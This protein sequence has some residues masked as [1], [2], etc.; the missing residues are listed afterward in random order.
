M[1]SGVGQEEAEEGVFGPVA[2]VAGGG[3]G[4]GEEGA[5][6]SVVGFDEGD[7]GIGGDLFEGFG[8]D[9]DEGIVEGV[10]DERGDGD[11][12]EDAGG[13]G[14]GVVVF[15][16][17]EA[18][19]E[20]GDAVVEVAQGVD[21]GGAVAVVGAGE[22]SGLAAEAAEEGA[23]KLEFV[24]AVL[25]AVQGVG[26]GGEVYGGRDSDDGVKL[27]RG[28]RAEFAGELEDEVAAHGVADERDGFEGVAV[29]EE[30]AGRRAHRWRGR[31]GRG[32]G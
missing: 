27:R 32:W 24:E 20:R 31:S 23:E 2:V 10:E 5:V 25:R 3:V 4:L 15:G 26:G 29:G 30:A 9:A 14:A 16:A 22:E 6:A 12:V 11:A 18:G 28:C 8:G 21:A 19:V 7:V 17:G 13:G 1:D